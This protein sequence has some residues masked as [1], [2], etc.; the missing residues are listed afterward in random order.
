VLTDA[1]SCVRSSLCI[2]APK[3][4]ALPAAADAQLLDVAA[5][6]V[7]ALQANVASG[8]HACSTALQDFGGDLLPAAPA[9]ARVAAA[10]RLAATATQL[11]ETACAVVDAVADAMPGPAAQPGDGAS[12]A[13]AAVV[14]GSDGSGSG[15]ARARTARGRRGGGGAAV[16]ADTEVA[17]RPMRVLADAARAQCASAAPQNQLLRHDLRVAGGGRLAA[18]HG[19]AIAAAVRTVNVAARW[20]GPEDANCVGF[21]GM[22]AH[23][24][25]LLSLMTSGFIL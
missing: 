17:P 14:A 20:M 15:G 23:F 1:V 25:V 2:L 18:P 9:G 5:V 12:A 16:A 3:P 6:L 22:L 7:E 21:R 11:L 8:T 19:S 24:D 13:G 10:Q 4:G